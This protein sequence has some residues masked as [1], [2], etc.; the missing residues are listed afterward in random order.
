MGAKSGAVF[1]CNVAKPIFKLV[2]E[3]G[4]FHGS[5]FVRAFGLANIEQQR[6]VNNKTLFSAGSITKVVTAVAFM[7]L[8]ESGKVDLDDSINDQLDFK[9]ENP[10]NG[11]SFD[12]TRIL[13]KKL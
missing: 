2:A 7:Q 10:A 3:H 8:V 9:V 12:G 6:K 11:G 5:A 4:E 13:E 1:E